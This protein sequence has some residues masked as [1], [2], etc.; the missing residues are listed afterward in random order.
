MCQEGVNYTQFKLAIYQLI[1]Q[2]KLME[3][4]VEQW[5]SL[6]HHD[7]TEKLSHQF[8]IARDKI[9]EGLEALEKALSEV[10]RLSS[11]GESE[12]TITPL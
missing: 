6:L 3:K 11:E 2:G 12:V 4:S 7:K 1:E 5:K 9:F 10:N 8:G